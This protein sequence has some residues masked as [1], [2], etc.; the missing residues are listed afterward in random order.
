[1]REEE[2][3]VKFSDKI[4]LSFSV[5]KFDSVFLHMH[6]NPQL[7]IVLDGEFDVQ[8]GEE[9]FHAKENDVFIINQRVFHQMHS[10]TETLILSVLI[11]QFGFALDQKEADSLHFNLNSMKQGNSKKHDNIRYLVNSIVKFNTMENIN[12]IY[13]NRAIAYSLFAQLMNDFKSDITESNQKVA[14]YDTI[15]K[16]TAYVNDNYNKKLSLQELSIHFNYSIAYLS[17]LFKQSLGNNFIDYY[18]S[19]RINY[20]LNDLIYSNKSIEEL[21]L[22]HGFEN[23][24]SYVRAFKKIYDIYP[25]EYRKKHQANNQN[26]SYDP[27]L[28][29]KDSLDKILK[30]YDT[31]IYKNENKEKVRNVENIVNVDFND[32]KIDLNSPQI[33][34]LNL[35]ST[36]YIFYEEIKN[37]LV[38]IQKDI[39]FKHITL[40]NL[41]D[42]EL[43]LYVKKDKDYLFN[44][45]LLDSII[46]FLSSLNIYP[47]FKFEYQKNMSLS[48]FEDALKQF[49][50][51]LKNKYSSKIL[52]NFLV[53]ITFDTPKS[54]D[55]LANSNDYTNSYTRI[56]KMIKS[57]V[58]SIKFGAPTFYKKDIENTDVFKN[59]IAYIKLNNI[60]LDFFPINYLNKDEYYLQKNKDELK[61]F[62][63]YLK[64]NNLFFEKKV[65]FENINF[66]NKNNLLNDT[67][68]ASNY[69]CKNLIDNIKS[70]GA[71]S[72]NIF[73]DKE[74]IIYT[75]KNPFKGY[76]G[77]VTYN[78]IKK[79][80]YNAYI[81]FSKLGDKLLKKSNN[82]IVTTKGNDVAI[83][84]NNYN[85]YADLYANNE[86][87][88]ISENNRYV[89]FPKSTNINFRFEINNLES[90]NVIIKKS[91]IS[92][93]SG[94]AYDKALSIGDIDL[95]TKEELNSLNR[96]SDINFELERK[97]LDN[98]TLNLDITIA[99][100]E[101]I[102][103]EIFMDK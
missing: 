31:F 1:M 98:N 72:K 17:R 103:I 94:S 99:P 53:S 95:L 71:Y 65:F 6:S 77:L 92:K 8:I 83:L 84:I 35:K 9:N 29:K 80:S 89:C 49:I 27:A 76:P 81:F 33:N 86:Y 88:E 16:I 73:I 54:F 10:N 66:T 24:R 87:Y 70:I 5:I 75:S 2:S 7:I 19:L 44:P 56:Y 18:D 15:T 26:D 60:E 96:L 74:D 37:S 90:K 28:L 14:S 48:K 61:E 91:Y 43:R 57:E 41:F 100:L 23:S 11:D 30:Q 39:G 64:E 63:N 97:T 40:T 58:K 62:I 38:Q 59:F 22:I 4:P 12:S 47:Y 52:S 67:L 51:H 46:D 79:A 42:E 78:N 50:T 82:Y 32:S 68:Y 102:L 25:S 45:Y 36:K 69:L 34:L 85:H 21:S 93:T 55:E 101:T 3:I 13:T 20:S